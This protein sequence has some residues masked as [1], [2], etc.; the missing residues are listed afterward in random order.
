MP[1]EELPPSFAFLYSNDTEKQL[2]VAYRGA[3]RL[4]DQFM[5]LGMITHSPHAF[6]LVVNQS[7]WDRGEYDHLRAD[8]HPKAEEA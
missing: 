4:I 3:D 2:P 1:T 5:I 8:K 7:D 6:L